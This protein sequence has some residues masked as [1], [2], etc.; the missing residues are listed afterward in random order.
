MHGQQNIIKLLCV[1][2]WKTAIINNHCLKNLTP[3]LKMEAVDSFDTLVPS[4]E[5]DDGTS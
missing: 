2:T 1:I 3:T 4:T 5:V